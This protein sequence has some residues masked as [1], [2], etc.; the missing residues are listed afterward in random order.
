MAQDDTQLEE[1]D[2]SALEI[3][4]MDAMA[5][6]GDD[7]LSIENPVDGDDFDLSGELNLLGNNTDTDIDLSLAKQTTDKIIDDIAPEIEAVGGDVDEVKQGVFD[8]IAPEDLPAQQ[9][10]PVPKV[11]EQDPDELLQ[12][13]SSLIETAVTQFKDQ[14]R[15]DGN[16]SDEEINIP[17]VS[18][19]DPA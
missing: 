2:D 16:L 10:Y 17:S 4:L 19:S 13:A 12:E 3:A 1:Q 14:L 9:V 18:S 11:R 6:S 8:D 5:D 7:V 15:A